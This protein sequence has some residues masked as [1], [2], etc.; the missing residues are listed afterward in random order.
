MLHPIRKTAQGLILL[1]LM[2]AIIVAA[3]DS[4]GAGWKK[5]LIADFT[6]TQTAYSDSWVGGEAGAVSWVGN[7]NGVAEK[8]LKPWLDFRSTLR[9][10]FGQTLTQDTAKEWSKP[11]KSTDLID[12]ENVGRFTLESYLD[13]FVAF[14]L[15]SQ[16]LDASFEPKKRSFTPLKLTESAGLTRKF[17]ERETD[18]VISRLGFA[19]RQIF[20]NVI[21]DTTALSTTDSTLTDGGIES[22]TDVTYTLSERLRYTG[23]LTLYRAFFFSGKDEVAGTAFEDDWKAIDVNWENIVNASITRILTVNFYTQFLYDKQ[24]TRKGRLKQ[25]LGIGFVLKLA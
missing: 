10:S 17:Y 22:V 9:L 7:V 3:T 4:T 8:Q 2:P 25:T 24:V 11:R 23:K 16:F 5:S 12:W 15:E 6:A 20:K 14:R 19:L 18:Q 21:I 13:P 1:L